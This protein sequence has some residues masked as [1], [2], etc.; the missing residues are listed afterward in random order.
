MTTR[1]TLVLARNPGPMTFEGTNSWLLHEPGSAQAVAVDP[2]PEDGPHFDALS[3]AAAVRGARITTV[4][5]SHRHPDHAAGVRAF[6]STVDAPVAGYDPALADVVLAGGEVLVAGGLRI[7]VLATPGHSSDSLSFRLPADRAV[8]TGDAVL[9]RGAPAILHPDGRLSDMIS[10][11]SALRSGVCDR[12]GSVLLPGHGPPI[13]HP[14]AM[15]DGALA[16]RRRRLAQIA[17]AVDEGC[18]T[19]E[20]IT[21]LLYAG[22]DPKLRRAALATVRAYLAYLENPSAM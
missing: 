21:E 16:A 17:A 19:A 3:A 10:S 13:R 20:C 18:D 22:L 2:G 14:L 7:E 8:L 9:G 15:L 11:L 5:L 1:A 12:T 4:L 6:A